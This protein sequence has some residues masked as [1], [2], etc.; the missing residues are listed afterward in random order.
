MEIIGGG[1]VLTYGIR[2]RTD[3][4]IKERLMSRIERMLR[5]KRIKKLHNNLNN[6]NN[7]LFLN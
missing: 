4:E 2:K 7:L 6:N 5:E 3:S 1:A